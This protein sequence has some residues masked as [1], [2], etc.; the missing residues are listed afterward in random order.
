MPGKGIINREC[1]KLN[2]NRKVYMARIGHK[3]FFEN[4]NGSLLISGREACNTYM[5][6]NMLKIY[7][8]RNNMP[9]VVLSGHLDLL[10]EL[11]K[12][13]EER[14]IFVFKPDNKKYH[15]MYGMSMQQVCNLINLAGH[16]LG[17]SM[18]MDKV[19]LYAMAIINIVEQK[20]P[21][22]LSAISQI[23]INDDEYIA[24]YAELNGNS[25]VIRDNILG[26]REAGIMF[27]R[28]VEK[29]QETF[30]NVAERETDTKSN[31][32]TKCLDNGKIT[33]VYQPCRNQKIMNTHLKEEIYCIIQRHKKVRIILDEAIFNDSEDDLL[34]YLV[35]QKRQGSIELV[36]CS[37]NVLDMLK[38]IKLD[39]D[40]M[41]IFNHASLAITEEVSKE[42]FGFYQYH[43]PVIMT[44]RPPS[45]FFSLKSDVRWS[46]ATEERL[47]VR[48][49]DLY[50]GENPL[51][52]GLREM[53]VIKVENKAEIY[54]VSVH[55]FIKNMSKYLET[56]KN[57]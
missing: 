42:L 30:E 23:L 36:A 20:Y 4:V 46:I 14:E 5:L 38:G 7:S 16:E 37:E 54:L 48:S 31:I 2:M 56:N 53:M 40:N 6:I 8:E 47:R 49:V 1:R 27:R 11:S 18:L 43:Y 19:L 3:D 10:E 28:I 22:S 34:T 39:F 24:R 25:D 50:G 12:L 13:Q 35:Q 15:P 26:N 17:C 51:L 45:I 41:C 9:N 44:G 55:Q 57:T 21:I 32:L 29:L 33:A 52:G